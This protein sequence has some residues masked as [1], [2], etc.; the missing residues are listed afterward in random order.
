MVKEEWGQPFDD[1]GK[2][3]TTC[4]QKRGQLLGIKREDTNWISWGGDGEQLSDKG[5]GKTTE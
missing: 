3:K 1:T 2:R 5:E 4:W